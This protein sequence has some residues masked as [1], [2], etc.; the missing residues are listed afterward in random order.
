M[1]EIVVGNV[2]QLWEQTKGHKIYVYGA[3]SIAIRTGKY[4]EYL[5]V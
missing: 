2:K 4:I 5:G 1:N 3:K